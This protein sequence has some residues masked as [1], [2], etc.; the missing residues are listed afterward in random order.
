[1]DP[2]REGNVNVDFPA[3]DSSLRIETFFQ[4][5]YEVYDL[6]FPLRAQNLA[7]ARRVAWNPESPYLADIRE[8]TGQ[9]LETALGYCPQLD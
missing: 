2:G 5:L 6:R 9:N 7:A 8:V 3:V 4:R 1:M